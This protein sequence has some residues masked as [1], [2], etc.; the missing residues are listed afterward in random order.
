MIRDL[1]SLY[2]IPNDFK[3]KNIK[4]FLQKLLKFNTE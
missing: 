2:M 3:N 4:G 1:A